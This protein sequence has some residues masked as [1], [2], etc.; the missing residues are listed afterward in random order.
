M[1]QDI[2]P[3]I[4][5]NKILSK[6]QMLEKLE[7]YEC[8]VIEELSHDKGFV[9]RCRFSHTFTYTHRDEWC[10]RCSEPKFQQET[11]NEINNELKVLNNP[12]HVYTINKYGLCEIICKDSHIHK[13]DID[14]IPNSCDICNSEDCSIRQAEH[15]SY[16]W[17]GVSNKIIDC[18]RLTDVDKDSSC[19]STSDYNAYTDVDEDSIWDIPSDYNAC[20]DTDI[21]IMDYNTD[22]YSDGDF[23]IEDQDDMCDL[24]KIFKDTKTFEIDE[25][26]DVSDI[27][28]SEKQISKP[29]VNNLPEIFQMPDKRYIIHPLEN[30]HIRNALMFIHESSEL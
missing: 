14:E 12:F 11:I 13:I 16:I 6:V 21:D 24:I 22:Y 7:L 8:K 15:D 10:I 29:Y 3:L 18:D 30:L 26:D 17:N 2:Q 9:C 23:E 19:Y 28:E 27:K 4:M 5:T 20:E 25:K 1:C